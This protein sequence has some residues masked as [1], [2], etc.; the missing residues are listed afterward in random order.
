MHGDHQHWHTEEFEAMI[1]SETRKVK[2]RLED[3]LKN[4]QFVLNYQPKVDLSTGQTEG[5]EA[6]IRWQHPQ[7]GLLAFIHSLSHV[8]R[9]SNAYHGRTLSSF[10]IECL[11]VYAEQSRRNNAFCSLTPLKST[12]PSFSMWATRP[13]NT[14]I[15][16]EVSHS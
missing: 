3:A 12:D 14:T 10:S 9:S 8:I 11:N 7:Q 6:L 16:T 15:V 2:G 1:F 4:E 5:Y 13:N